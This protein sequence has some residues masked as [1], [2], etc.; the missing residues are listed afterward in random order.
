MLGMTY[1]TKYLASWAG[2]LTMHSTVNDNSHR[3]RRDS[4][5]PNLVLA[6]QLH[7]CTATCTVWRENSAG[8]FWLVWR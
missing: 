2:G 6:V 8:K 7:I 5:G 4:Q 3:Q 1:L